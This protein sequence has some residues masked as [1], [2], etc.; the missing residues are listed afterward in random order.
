[1]S[2]WLEELRKGLMEICVLNL[3]N[4]GKQQGYEIF[5]TLKKIDKLAV[6]DCKLYPLL[7]E[8]QKDGKIA[9]QTEEDASSQPKDFFSLTAL[10]RK[11]M[12]EMDN[13][14]D[15]LKD[16]ISLFVEQSRKEAQ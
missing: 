4:Q 16:D 10:G 7:V 6:S 9:I 14:W 11:R 12:Q 5:Q 2:M 15:S 1:M 8:L 13:Y 3:L